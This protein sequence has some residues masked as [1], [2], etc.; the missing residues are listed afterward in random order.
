MIIE[1]RMVKR[2]KG[3]ALGRTRVAAHQHALI[4]ISERRNTDLFTF[5]VTLFHE[6]L[7]VWTNIM[8]TNGAA[9]DMRKEH[10]FIYAMHRPLAKNIPLMG[11]K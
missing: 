10:Q 1:L 6:L 3:D 5:G 7:H 8:R 11:R 2:L 4:E 9:I